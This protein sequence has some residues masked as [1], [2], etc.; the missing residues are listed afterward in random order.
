MNKS[1]I[2]V[3]KTSLLSNLQFVY[4]QNL[5]F[6]KS[7]YIVIS[8]NFPSF[9]LFFITDF[10]DHDLINYR[11]NKKLTEL[12]KL[13]T[14]S[15]IFADKKLNFGQ[16]VV[17]TQ[18][19]QERVKNKQEISNLKNDE[20][21]KSILSKKND[22]QNEKYIRNNLNQLIQRPKNK[23]PKSI[24]KGHMNSV[25]T[26]APETVNMELTEDEASMFKYNIPENSKFF[27]LKSNYSS[28][29]FSSKKSKS[30]T[31]AENLNLPFSSDYED[32]DMKYDLFKK[33]S[34]H[35]IHLSNSESLQGNE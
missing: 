29:N 1:N 19:F 14:M 23:T 2:H 16:D 25:T 26:G 27:D 21:I 33:Q 31:L 6:I 8:T 18:T 5:N 13:Y 4:G 32:V 20:P 28:K 3:C 7:S 15:K 34:T 30:S 22:K 11:K 9:F 12:R 17:L 10:K 24:S 35:M